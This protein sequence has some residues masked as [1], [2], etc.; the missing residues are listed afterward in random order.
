MKEV[1]I[2][3]QK[4][5]IRKGGNVMSVGGVLID[6]G[7]E[8]KFS[9]F[10]KNTETFEVNLG[11]EYLVTVEQEEDWKDKEGRMHKGGHK[12]WYSTL[13]PL[14]GVAPQM[15]E[16]AVAPVQS[17]PVQDLPN[18][19]KV[20]PTETDWDAKELRGHRR[21]CMAIASGLLLEADK[22][23][24]PDVER[25]ALLELMADKMVAYVYGEK[26]IPKVDTVDDIPMPEDAPDWVTE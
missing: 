5:E 1:G 26:E 2:K 16:A 17:I 12:A 21:A 6:T 24:E 18:P 23:G 3:V 7:Q 10:K 13:V 25:I 19:I 14:E 8:F 22:A 20:E 4:M 15:K 11:S 9:M